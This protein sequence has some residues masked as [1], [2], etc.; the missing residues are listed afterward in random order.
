MRVPKGD[1]C[2]NG[3]EPS[4]S[5][6]VFVVP[7]GEETTARAKTMGGIRGDGLG[8]DDSPDR[9]DVRR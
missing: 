8:A 7:M 5:C 4:S 9:I 1:Q 3:T 2:F 6:D